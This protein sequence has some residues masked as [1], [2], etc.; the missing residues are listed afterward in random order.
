MHYQKELPLYKEH[1]QADG[2]KIREQDQKMKDMQRRFEADKVLLESNFH[3][4]LLDSTEATFASGRQAM[5]SL[6]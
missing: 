1:A 2:R 3:N 6:Y 4:T 5:A